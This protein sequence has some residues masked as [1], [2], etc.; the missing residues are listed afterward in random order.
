MIDII[1][2]VYNTP[3]DDLKRCFDSILKQ[4]Y[5]DYKVYII[6]DGSSEE[7]KKFIDIYAKDKKNFYVRHIVNSGVSAARNVGLNLAKSEY[8]TFVDSDDTIEKNFLK[9]SIKYIEK[10]DLDVII[11]GYNEIKNNKIVKER[12][13]MP[14]VHIYED[15]KL[16]LFFKKLLSSKTTKNNIEIGDC[17]TGRIYTRLFKRKSIN[18]LRFNENI[19]ISEDTL[20]MIDY[21][22]KV[23]KIGIVDKIW[24]N[25]YK[26][27]YS[28]TSLANKKILISNIK[29]FIKQ[30]N[31]N[32]FNEQNKIIKNAYNLRIKKAK[33]YIDEL[34]N[35]SK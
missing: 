28:I 2:P 22:Y 4:T 25:Y 31:N 21:M 30:I 19:K 10:Y 33:K 23:K 29:D 6:D 32:L 24:Y 15:E 13:C 7:T 5:T 20:F 26:N 8:V 17:P 27:D 1:I 14:G 11:G 18:D 9:Q 35:T 16:I 34:K 3:S 12:K